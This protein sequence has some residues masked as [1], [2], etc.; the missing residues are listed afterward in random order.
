[1]RD[2]AAVQ[3]HLELQYVSPFPLLSIHH[4]RPHPVHPHYSSHLHYL[5]TAAYFYN[6]DDPSLAR[7]GTP[8][9]CLSS[10]WHPPQPLSRNVPVLTWRLAPRHTTPHLVGVLSFIICVLQF[11]ADIR[12]RRLFPYL[13][14]C[15]GHALRPSPRILPPRGAQRC[16]RKSTQV[17]PRVRPPATAHTLRAPSRTAPG[18]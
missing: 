7:D 17:A 10:P 12:H 3:E 6:A 14:F 18:R 5:R 11:A 4:L 9:R 16:T 13:R 15:E 8:V 1:M 2:P